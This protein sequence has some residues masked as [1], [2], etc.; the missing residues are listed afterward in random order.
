MI[1]VRLSLLELAPPTILNAKQEL[2]QQLLWKEPVTDSV[3]GCE[4]GFTLAFCVLL[5]LTSV[6]NLL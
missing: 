5:I 6:R 2:R 3:K 1:P 4:E